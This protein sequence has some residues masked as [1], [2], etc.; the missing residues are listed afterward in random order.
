MAKKVFPALLMRNL[1]LKALIQSVLF[2]VA[3]IGMACFFLFRSPWRPELTGTARHGTSTVQV[4]LRSESSAPSGSKSRHLQG[5]IKVPGKK[6]KPVFNLAMNFN[7]S[8][9]RGATGANSD[10]SVGRDQGATGEQDGYDTANSMDLKKEGELYPFFRALW[11]KVDASLGYPDD[12]VKERLSG[13][14]T[15]Q[16]VLDRGGVFHGEI[17]GVASD[18][19]YLEAYVLAILFHALHDPLPQNLWSDREQMILVMRFDFRTFSYGEIPPEPKLV[20]LKN[21]L[22]FNRGGYTESRLSQAIDKFMTHYFPPII[23]IPGAFYIDFIRA[24]QMV[25]NYRS[26]F[27]MGEDDL[28]GERLQL[29]RREWESVIHKKSAF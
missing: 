6:V 9:H 28:R 1:T 18:Q 3:L 15:A 7:A 29:S 14:V 27:K 11:K 8:E 20:N 17:L 10:R 13:H 25:Q 2:H 21:V 4:T 22:A 26:R 5:Q 19:P 16:V 23:P 12:F 24:Y